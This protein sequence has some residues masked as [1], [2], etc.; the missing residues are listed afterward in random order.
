MSKPSSGF[1]TFAT[2]P[3]SSKEKEKEIKKKKKSPPAL[4]LWPPHVYK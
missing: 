4:S 3:F 1:G 2:C